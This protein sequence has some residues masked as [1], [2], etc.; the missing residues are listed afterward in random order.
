MYV[1]SIKEQLCLPDQQ[2]ESLRTN[3]A[4]KITE[5]KQV[6]SRLRDF[7]TEVEHLQHLL[8]QGRIR[9]TRD[10]EAW[11]V[12]VYKASEEEEDEIKKSNYTFQK[13]S[14]NTPSLDSD[15]V[16]KRLN[17]AWTRS[18]PVPAEKEPRLITR[19][20]SKQSV[21]SHSEPLES[22]VEI[23]QIR[24]RSQQKPMYPLETTDSQETIIYPIRQGTL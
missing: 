21:Q 24:P 6:Y 7:K 15:E 3:L 11:Y 17:Q 20:Y 9:M 12:E 10:F 5:Y 14:S 2:D 22:S 4:S 19:S 13:S 18:S 8:E 23:P 16:S 1:E